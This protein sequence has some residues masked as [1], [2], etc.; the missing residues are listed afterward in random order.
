MS[1]IFQYQTEQFADIKILRYQ[2]PGFEELS[3]SQKELIYY[4]AEAARCGRDILFDQN[5]KNN[6]S[7]RRT[8][9]AIARSY[10]G[11][12]ESDEFKSFLVY[13]KRVWFSNGIHHHYSMDKF[14]PEFSEE[15][16]GE[17]LSN[18]NYELLP[19]LEGEDVVGLLTR[20]VPVLFDEDVD[21][22]RVV[23]NPELDLIKDSANNYYEGVC[24]KEAEDFYAKMEKGDPERP[25]SAGLN[26]KLVKENGELIEKTWKV[27]GMYSEAIEKIVF[28][29]EK[30]IPVADSELQRESLVK[31]VEFYKTGDLKAFDEYSI[32]WVKDLDTHVD[33]VNGFIEVYGD[34]L[35]IKGSWES[36]VN[37]KD[38]EATKRAVII[39]DNA[40]WFEDHSPVDKRFKKEKVKGVS[41]KVITVVMLGGDCHPATP[42]G[43][44]LP[45]AEWIRKEHGSKSVTIDNITHAYHQSSLKSGMIDEFAYSKEEVARAKEHGYLGG[46]LHTDLHE[47]LGHG[48]GQ[49]LPGVGMD[50]LKNY[51]STLEEARAD[52]FALYYMMDTKMVDLGLMPCLEVAKAEYDGYIRNGLITQLTRIDLGKEIEESH[53]RNRQLI[54]KWV[55]EKGESDKVIVKVQEEGKTYYVVN[56]YLKLRTLF[57]D[58]LKEVQR[59]K[60]EGDFEA[61][62]RLVEDYAVKV[63]VELHKE[64]KERFE[65]LNLAAY[66]GFINPD[67]HPVY[68][69]GKIVDVRISYPMDFMEQML[70]YGERYS[71]L[72]NIN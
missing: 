18:T 33:V 41:A 9:E 1:K 59:I 20:L 57:G 60:S 23:L 31:L 14:M 16:F 30:A 71:F 63:D 50:A 4:L 7:I 21:A 40:Q 24:E 52:L 25:I 12:R 56:D 5:N 46:N 35:A 2:V 26:S 64:V 61:G 3:L 70:E 43:V 29:L 10:D 66:A 69:E 65:K 45:N 34:A 55:F 54:A 8:L 22:K 68:E 13:A 67:Y 28:W 48:S 36:I 72:P 38:I 44:N 32:L 15:Y 6:L 53:M 51:H 47:C 42:I 11:D 58:L 62:K 39:S 37:F 49:L 17:L 19:L 27:G